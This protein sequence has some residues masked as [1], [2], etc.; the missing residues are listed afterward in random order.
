MSEHLGVYSDWIQHA[1]A[2]AARA[3]SLP[4]S[5]QVRDVVRRMVSTAGT[6]DGPSEVEVERRWTAGGLIG[7]EI[8]Y[9]VGFGPRTHAYVLK[10]ANATEPL[11]GVLALHG[12]D[13]FKYYGK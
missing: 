5:E 9:A 2:P 7:E 12:H 6:A 11:P 3:A 10:P 13:G 8:S 1:S 4:A